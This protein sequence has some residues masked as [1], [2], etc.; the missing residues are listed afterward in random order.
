M[1]NPNRHVVVEYKNRRSRKATNA[2]WGTMDLK[3]IASDIESELPPSSDAPAQLDVLTDTASHAVARAPEPELQADTEEVTASGQN[4]LP[5]SQND[6]PGDQGHT[7][8][9][10][11]E[12][13]DE[14]ISPSE[15][16]SRKPLTKKRRN[17]DRAETTIQSDILRELATLEKENAELKQ[18]LIISLRAENDQ[19]KLMLLRL[20]KRRSGR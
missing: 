5:G 20:A 14:A 6:F 17:R 2:L 7:G 11:P 16:T 10:A 3:S 12:R 13:P 15:T 8:P 1:K 19:L 18:E 4:V 9:D